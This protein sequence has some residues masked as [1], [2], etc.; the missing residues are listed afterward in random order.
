MIAQTPRFTAFIQRGGK[1]YVATCPELDVV[2]QGFTVEEART[3]LSEAVQLFL[4]CAD[5][6]EIADRLLP[7]SL[8]ETES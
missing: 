8:F 6:S 7:R 1:Y 2:S 4:E 5:P 3:N